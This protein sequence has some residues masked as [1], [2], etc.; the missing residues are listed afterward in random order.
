MCT[1]FIVKFISCIKF[2][3]TTKNICD[4]SHAADHVIRFLGLL[5]HFYILQAIKTWRCRRPGNEATHI[6][7]YTNTPTHTHTHTHIRCHWHLRI[8]HTCC[9]S[10]IWG[11]EA[12]WNL[13]FQTSF[14]DYNINWKHR[15][16]TFSH[17][18]VRLLQT[19]SDS[20]K[21]RWQGDHIATC[22]FSLGKKLIFSN[23]TLSSRLTVN[24]RCS[25]WVNGKCNHFNK[26][27]SCSVNWVALWTDMFINV[28]GFTRWHY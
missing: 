13:S 7:T 14:S 25:T 23:S 24:T 4:V 18:E 15:I 19:H 28:Y 3:T 12:D 2:L 10:N 1:P 8:I 17:S 26:Y 20:C 21:R 6:Y 22:W 16:T 27:S 5:F 9:C 11:K